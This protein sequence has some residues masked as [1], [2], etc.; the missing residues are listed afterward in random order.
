MNGSGQLGR[1]LIFCG[2]ILIVI[3]VLF[4][5]GDKLSW[6]R[7]GRLPGDFTWTNSSGTVR[8]YFPLMTGLLL[9]VL[10]SLIFWLLRR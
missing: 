9:S 4:L 5:F 7:L 10:L 6:L 8:I 3:G 1:L 2:A